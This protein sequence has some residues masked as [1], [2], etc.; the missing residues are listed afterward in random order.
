MIRA[1]H[2]G[3]VVLGDQ[4]HGLLLADL[5]IALVI[6]LVEL[7]LGAAEIGQA[8]GGAERQVFQL[9]I[10]GVDDVGGEGDGV[11]EW[12]QRQVFQLGIA[13]C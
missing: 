3:D 13:R 2:G 12:R 10:G 7:D 1:E 4:A 8:G 6:G 9:G 5:R 11:C